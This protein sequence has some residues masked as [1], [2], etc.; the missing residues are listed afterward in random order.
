MGR[1][2]ATGEAHLHPTHHK[3]GTKPCRTGYDKLGSAL[4]AVLGSG[5]PEMR[6][7]GRESLDFGAP[8]ATIG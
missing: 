2:L 4:V 6:V 3:K 7:D 5:S 1:V 8:K